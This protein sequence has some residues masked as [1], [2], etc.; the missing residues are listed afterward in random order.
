MYYVASYDTGNGIIG[1]L[2]NSAATNP[3]EFNNTVSLRP[4]LPIA[5][6]SLDNIRVIPN[7]Y[8]VT[9][10]WETGFN[11]H[12]IQFVGLPE[13]ATIKILNSNAE[14]IKTLYHDKQSSIEKWDLKNEFNQMVAAGVYFYFID[15][16]IG[17]KTG[18]FFVIL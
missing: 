8:I 18:K 2:E 15:T 1:P 12:I 9:E 5:T 16:P 13:K 7:P 14:L 11:E 17:Q 4:E 6:S 3:E 10:I